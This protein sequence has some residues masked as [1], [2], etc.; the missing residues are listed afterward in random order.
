MVYRR[1]PG[2][3]RMVVGGLSAVA[4]VRRRRR[5]AQRERGRDFHVLRPRP[6]V[7]QVRVPGDV[8]L[9]LLPGLREV[10]EAVVLV[11]VVEA[12]GYLARRDA[13]A[14]VQRG[15]AVR[16]PYPRFVDGRV[17]QRG[18][19]VLL[20]DFRAYLRRALVLH[21][22]EAELLL[23]HPVRVRPVGGVVVYLLLDGVR[24]AQHRRR[25]RDV[26]L[27]PGKLRLE[28]VNPAVAEF[29]DGPR[30]VPYLLQYAHFRTP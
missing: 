7:G 4:P 2:N 14:R 13:A 8:Y 22:R 21:V 25:I 28:R 10:R 6:A 3:L 29:V 15:D 20:G 5:L 16:R 18:G 24:L 23:G 26:V 17:A 19:H 1:V 9:A 30:L 27:R 12:A 11:D